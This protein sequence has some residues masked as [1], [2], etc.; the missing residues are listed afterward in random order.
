MEI[1]SETGTIYN[2]SKDGDRM[3][4]SITKNGST[5]VYIAPA[6]A[7]ITNSKGLGGVILATRA[8]GIK[9]EMP[10]EKMGIEK[11]LVEFMAKA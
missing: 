10:V 7:R 1:K 3:E 8:D 11:Q 6:K 5:T 2:L 4:I 9:M